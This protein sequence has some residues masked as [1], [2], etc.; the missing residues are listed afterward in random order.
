VVAGTLDNVL[1]QNH[2]S[3]QFDKDGLYLMEKLA[4]V[5]QLQTFTMLLL[6]APTAVNLID[7]IECLINSN[8]SYQYATAMFKVLFAYS[9]WSKCKL[10]A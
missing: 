5:T 3:T 8:I 6:G 10:C 2:P 9:G 7:L 1:F 4:S